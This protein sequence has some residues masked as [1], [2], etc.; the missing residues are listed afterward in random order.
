VSAVDV[1]GKNVVYSWGVAWQNTNFPKLTRPRQVAAD[2]LKD[3]G[4]ITKM[5]LSY[6]PDENDAGCLVVLV[7]DG[8]MYILKFLVNGPIDY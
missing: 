5:E 7:A 4:V 2:A 3:L 6:R 1:T 8:S